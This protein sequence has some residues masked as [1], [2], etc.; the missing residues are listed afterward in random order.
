MSKEIAGR[1]VEL[2]VA[3]LDL[4][5]RVQARWLPLLGV[6][7]D[8]RGDVLEIALDGRGHSILSP[9]EILLEET[10]RG[11]VALEIV[12]ADDT[13]ETL[14]FREPLRLEHAEART[15]RERT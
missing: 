2:D 11:L 13:V 12:A 8:V 3:S 9:R 5:D 1:R 7:F 10:E 4:G 15:D 14:R 6:V